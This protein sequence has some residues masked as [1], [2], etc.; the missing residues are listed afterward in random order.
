MNPVCLRSFPVNEKELGVVVDLAE[1]G[2][3]VEMLCS[4]SGRGLSQ[5]LNREMPTDR[6]GLG[7]QPKHR[8][9]A[10]NLSQWASETCMPVS[11]PHT[12]PSSS[13]SFVQET[14]I[15]PFSSEINHAF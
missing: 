13:A 6:V 3:H 2:V 9:L 10:G 8:L 15:K 5:S 4:R 11:C 12:E 1:D 14:S 7:H